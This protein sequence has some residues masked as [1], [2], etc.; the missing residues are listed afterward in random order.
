MAIRG[1][2]EG[3]IQKRHSKNIKKNFFFFSVSSTFNVGLD[4]N[5]PEISSLMLYR[6]NQPG[7]LEILSSLIT[8]SATLWCLLLIITTCGQMVACDL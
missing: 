2:W 6:L 7:A 1:I 3:V 8:V 4:V 5:D